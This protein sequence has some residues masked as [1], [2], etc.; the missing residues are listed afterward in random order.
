MQTSLHFLTT[1]DGVRIAYSQHGDGPSLVFVRGWISHL[2]MMWEDIHFRKYIE[3][4]AR[5]YKV[6]R[7]DVR[8][9]G[10]SERM[11]K[12]VNL[13]A[14]LLDLEALID[15]LGTSDVI[16]YGATFGGP[17][18]MLYAA[19]YPERVSRL[20]L[21]GTYARG[22]EITTR[23]RQIIITRTLR[24]FPEMAFLLLGHV[25]HP[26]PHHVSYRR[27]ELGQQM[28]S[29]PVAA[30]LYSLAFKIDITR[31]LPKIQV[32]TLVLHRRESQ[33]IPFRLGR[34][35]AS[36]IPGARFVTLSGTAHNTWEG[37]AAGALHE[38]SDFLGIDL[39]LSGPDVSGRMERKLTAIFS[40]DVQGYSRLMGDDEEATIRT[41]T[42]YRE[43][44]TILIQQ[45]RGRVV[46][47]PGD[48]LLAEFSSVV[49]AVEGAIEIQKE[50]AVR[51]A[52]LPKH[53]QML[54]RIGINV[55]DVLTDDGRLYGD[56]VNITARLEGLADA[57]GIC[58]SEA[59][60]TQV[61][62]KLDLRYE[63][64]GE[65]EVKNI[66]EPVRVYKVRLESSAPALQTY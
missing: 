62:N 38:I 53:R 57:G 13:E 25:T 56:G 49:N 46:D 10:L 40:A 21:E 14:L 43:V 65:R 6:T 20:I 63:Y 66:A 35:V 61:K 27:P 7:Y 51:N 24:L 52:E 33:S 15:Q 41:L 36:L 11:L 42:A 32:P 31:E 34:E 5:H 4:L 12:D 55:G 58:I 39:L 8:G 48:N 54:F 45:H 44:M 3:A 29:A 59:A 64:I 26:E 18:A 47:S 50:L 19:R 28:I 16:L 23:I 2:N 22:A 60:Y 30:K 1:R 9:N 37:D 17:I